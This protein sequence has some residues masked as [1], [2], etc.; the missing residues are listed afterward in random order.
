MANVVEYDVLILVNLDLGHSAMLSIAAVFTAAVASIVA[1]FTMLQPTVMVIL[2][3]DP[4]H[5]PT[6]S[7]TGINITHN[8]LHFCHCGLFN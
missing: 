6:G 2:D 3:P 4:I 8:E 7:G 5:A 1:V